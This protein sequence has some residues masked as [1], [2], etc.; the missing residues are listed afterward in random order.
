MLKSPYVDS[1]RGLRRRVCDWLV[2]VAP[3]IAVFGEEF[4]E[5]RPVGGIEGICV[6]IA[7]EK[8]AGVRP[9]VGGRHTSGPNW[10]LKYIGRCFGESVARSFFQCEYM[11]VRLRL[12]ANRFERPR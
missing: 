3:G 2:V 7:R 9:S 8:G 4:P 12:E 11:V 5:C 1:Y 10:V 6:W